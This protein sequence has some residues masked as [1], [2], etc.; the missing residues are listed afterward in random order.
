[1]LCLKGTAVRT[2]IGLTVCV[3]VLLAAS[4]LA[5]DSDRSEDDIRWRK[6]MGWNK[7]VHGVHLGEKVEDLIAR[8]PYAY[9]PYTNELEVLFDYPSAV[10]LLPEDTSA[11]AEMPPEM[12]IRVLPEESH[13][14]LWSGTVELD[15]A[16]R[17]QGLFTLPELPTGTFRVEYEFGGTTLRASR[18]FTRSYFAFEHNDIG[19]IHA[20]YSPFT[21]VKVDDNRVSVVNRT[22]AI[23]EVGLFD[24]VVSKGREL[25]ADPMQLVVETTDGKRVEWKTGWFSD[26][27]KGEAIHPDT[28]LFETTAK[29][30]DFGVQSAI[31]I[32]EDGCAKVEMTLKPKSRRRKGIR[33][34]WIEMPL[35]ESEA[36]LCHL[37]G[38]NSMRHNYAGEVP[39]GG[40]VTWINQAWRPARFDVQPFEGDPPASYEVWNARQLMHW[41]SQRWNFAPYVWLGAAERGLAWFGDHTAGYATDGKRGIQR[42]RIEPGKVVLRVELIQQPVTLDAPRTFVFGLQASPTKPMKQ[43]WRGYNVPGGGGM[44]VNV[45]GGYNCAW[46]YPDPKEWRIVEEIVSARN[47]EVGPKNEEFR[48]FFEQMNAK[49]QFPDLKVHGRETWMENVLGFAGRAGRNPNGITV[50]Y[51]EFQTSGHHPESYEYMDEWDLDSWCRYRKHDYH[52]QNR[53]K[54]AWGP[55]ARTANQ[56]SWRDFAVYYADQWMRRGVGIYY[57]NTPPRPD[58]NHFNLREKGV[59]WQNCIWGHRKYFRRVWKRSRQLMAKGMTPIDP[60]T[61]GTDNERRM[62]LHTVGHV[63]NCQVL[64][65]TTWWDATLGV[66]QPGQW[67]PE[68]GPSAEQKRRQVEERGFVILP[69]PKKGK[70]GSPLPLPP[71]YLRAMT[72]GRM[73]G[74]IP[75]YRHALRSEDAFGGLGI[76]YGATG[77]P[78]EEIL[79]HRRLSDKAM[80][81]VHEVR[82]GGNPYKHDG[83]R[84]LMAAFGEY[85]YGTPGVTVHNYWAKNPRLTVDNPDIKWIVLE[86]PDHPILVL[87]QSYRAEATRCKIDLPEGAATLDL[88]TRRLQSSD[89]PVLFE[90][91]YGTRLLLIAESKQR[92]QPLAWDEGVLLQADFEFGLPPGWRSRGPARPRIVADAESPG[93]H[94]L[95]ITHGH[96]SRNGISGTIHGDYALSFRFRLPEVAGKPPYPQFYGFLQ[97]IHRRTAGWPKQ[98]GQALGMGIRNNPKGEPELAMSFT[99]YRNGEKEQFENVTTNRL[100]EVGS[101]V[102]LDTEWHTVAIIV[103]GDRH[104]LSIDGHEVF[105]GESDVTDGGRLKL[106]PGWCSRWEDRPPYVEVDDLVCREL[107][108]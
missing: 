21:P 23:N 34:A 46:H 107:D 62:R 45:W 56:E 32:E 77:R 3:A 1:M 35:K 11:P 97:L 28:A 47:P 60:L 39:R 94:L 79:D 70:R 22:Y 78:K 17:G 41:H 80:G 71:D 67:I 20:V 6:K 13:D 10:K 44:A 73:A 52:W 8:V 84:T 95:R 101:L 25:L 106:G 40:K 26:G 43:G 108:D 30:R 93:N 55:Q 57:D 61:R 75:H 51:E 99:T 33:R 64:P 65:F 63:T 66:E 100:N 69:T 82:G 85:G 50:Y 36:P 24:S 54:K 14:V 15:E 81:L 89:Q 59:S 48:A 31:R 88:F 68:N 7:Q 42:L 87:L 102:P 91:D 86:K 72:M 90:A 9:Y 76:S 18:N 16:G 19:E 4:V 38:M 98:N 37:V 29:S 58:Y 27:V 49:R 53:G 74:L 92:L 105:S 104:K 12:T 2:H 103:R 5:A 96:P 83:I